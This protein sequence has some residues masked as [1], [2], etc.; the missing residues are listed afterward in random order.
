MRDGLRIG[1]WRVDPDVG[2]L[3]RGE[4]WVQLELKAMDLLV[5]LAEHPG[6]VL[7]KERLIRA[8]WPGTFVTDEVL[9]NAIWQLRKALGDD[10]RNPRYIETLPRRGYRLVAPVESGAASSR[11]AGGSESRT[12]AVLPQTHWSLALEQLK[13]ESDSGTLAAGL[14]MPATSPMPRR[15]MIS[16]A[17]AV[18]LTVSAILWFRTGAQAPAA[19]PRL[20]PLT[21]FL[22]N[23]STPAFSPY[24]DRIVFT[25]NGPKEDNYDIYVM[26]LGAPNPVRL[27]TDPAKECCPAWSPDGRR[28]AFVRS[29]AAPSVMVMSALG[30]SERELAKLSR[31]SNGIDWSPDGKFVAFPADP[32]GAGPAQIVLLAPDTG[33]RRVATLPPASSN[34]GDGWPRF[35]PDGTTLAFR[36]VVDTSHERI[37]VTPVNGPPAPGRLVT[38]A[39]LRAYGPIAWTRDSRELVFG[40]REGGATGMWRLAVDG[41]TRPVQVAEVG[42]EAVQPAISPRGDLLAYST[43]RHL[44]LDIWRLEL[45]NGH[46]ARDPIRTVASTG[47]DAAPDYSPDGK[48]IVFG[49]DRSGAYEIW[50]CN[51]DGTNPTQVTTLNAPMTGAPRWSPDGRTI[52]FDSTLGG[53]TEIY[54]VSADGGPAKRITNHP[55]SDFAPTWSRDGRW[56]YFTSDRTG[57]RQLWSMP[58]GGG[59][60][61]QL[62]KHGGVNATESGDGTTLYYVKDIDAPGLWRMPIGGGDEVLVNDAPKA[63]RYGQIALVKSGFYYV[64]PDGTDSPARYAIFFCEFGVRNLTRVAGLATDLWALPGLSLAPD[65][66]TI[67]FTQGKASGSDLMLLRNFR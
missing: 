41:G 5:Y 22:G 34:S 16:A 19:R 31:R 46:A 15:L 17:A 9:S 2:K 62:T 54:T 64:G 12:P 59:E 67:L 20:V 39:G 23:E 35:S 55:A 18:L 49:S 26:L 27:T 33:E 44:D 28:I 53:N 29:G 21:T 11:H 13:E 3:G 58:A 37:G 48:R 8:V 52:A 30:G 7:G 47:L 36:R 51:A 57:T 65:G 42:R 25:W 14:P 61:V 56:I 1:D 66:K 40:G 45:K 63:G 6:E 32:E 24:G 38:P 43:G 50:V 10:S 60:P 4:E